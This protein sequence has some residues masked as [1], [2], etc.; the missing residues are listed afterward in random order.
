M[1]AT[2]KVSSCVDCTTPIIGDRPRCPAC[3]HRHD[4]AK[5]NA[6]ARSLVAFSVAVLIVAVAAALL[7]LAWRS[8]Q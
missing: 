3:R 8:C 7:F 4:E 6:V 5:P 2:S 1:S